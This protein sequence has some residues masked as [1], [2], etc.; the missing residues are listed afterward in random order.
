MY[1]GI[2]LGTSEVKV[3]LLAASG[4]VI[5][6]AGSPFT[7]SRPHQ[8]W[9]EQN[10]EDW[11]TGTRAALAALRAKHPDEFAQIRGIGLSGQMHGAVLLDAQDRVLRPATGAGAQPPRGF[12]PD[13]SAFPDRKKRTGSEFSL[14]VQVYS[15][16]KII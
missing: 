1:L 15:L 13:F 2:D 3:L 4:R 14:I 7:V 12:Q 16:H 11:W 8:R 6:T 9:A 10:P 5:G